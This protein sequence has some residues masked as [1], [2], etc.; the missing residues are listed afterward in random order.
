MTERQKEIT[1]QKELR[2][3]EEKKKMFAQ[4]F[5]EHSETCFVEQIFALKS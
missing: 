4:R 2:N 5:L 1:E 3:V